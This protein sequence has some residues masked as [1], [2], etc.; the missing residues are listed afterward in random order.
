MD[1]GAECSTLG[2][3]RGGRTIAVEI[4]SFLGFSRLRDLEEAIGQYQVY[5]VVL[6]VT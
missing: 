1:L 5:R 4:Q 3:E 6:A 2:A